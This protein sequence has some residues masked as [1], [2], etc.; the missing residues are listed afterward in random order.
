MFSLNTGREILRFAYII[1]SILLFSCVS[2]AQFP[3]YYPFMFNPSVNDAHAR[4]IGRTEI[5]NN[6]GAGAIGCNPAYLALLEKKEVSVSGRMHFGS[7]YRSTSYEGAAESSY[8]P[9]VKITNISFAIPSLF[10]IGEYSFSAGISYN[11]HFDQGMNYKTEYSDY[12]DDF[13][14]KAESNLHGGMHTISPA[15]AVSI[16]DILQ[17]GI[18]FHQSIFSGTNLKVDYTYKNGIPSEYYSEWDE[19]ENPMSGRF[20]SLGQVLNLSE[21]VTIGL[22]YVSDIRQE[23]RD[24]KHKEKRLN[25]EEYEFEFNDSDI[26]VP[27]HFGFALNYR[28]SSKTLWAFEYQNRPFAGIQ[29]FYSEYYWLDYE[30]WHKQYSGSVYRIGAEFQKRIPLRLGIYGENIYYYGTSDYPEWLFGITCGTGFHFSGMDYDLYID[31]SRW[32]SDTNYTYTETL[33]DL[34]ITASYKF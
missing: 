20:F 6:N 4:P 5:L 13:T 3:L 33:F 34:G 7:V 21:K 2:Q 9:H 25:G 1:I 27:A 18:A 19:Y 23:F 17:I 11:T 12:Y 28:P 31:I 8:P 26:N 32:D 10:K 30:Y 14:T 16:G 24:G 15:L 29:Y 22:I